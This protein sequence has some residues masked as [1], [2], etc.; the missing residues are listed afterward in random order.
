MQAHKFFAPVFIT[1]IKS[2]FY[3]SYSAKQKHFH[4]SRKEMKAPEPV[5]MYLHSI[6]CSCC[7]SRNMLMYKSYRQFTYG[8]L[9]E[10]HIEGQNS[11]RLRINAENSSRPELNLSDILDQQHLR[12]A[13]LR[14]IFLNQIPGDSQ[15]GRVTTLSSQFLSKKKFKVPLTKIRI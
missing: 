8:V 14:K 3:Y 5:S 4:N 15:K 1:G 11:A 13:A 12:T 6:L 2:S 9:W 7:C 10:I